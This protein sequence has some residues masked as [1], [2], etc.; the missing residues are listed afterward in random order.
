MEIVS[1]PVITILC[2]L[3]GEFF[4]LVVLRKKTRYKYIPIIVGGI[5]GALG[6]II[7]FV[8]PEL[9]LDTTNPFMAIAVGIVSG[10]ASTGTNEL[11]KQMLKR[12][13]D[14]N[15]IKK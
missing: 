7:Y 11:V 13:E 12:K 8:S 10:L 1:I 5:G 4:K 9:L 3:A 14:E 2:Y 15:A 6:L